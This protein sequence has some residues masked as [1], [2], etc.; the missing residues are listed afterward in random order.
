MKKALRINVKYI[1]KQQQQLVN[2][3]YQNET[4]K[5]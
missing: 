5:W 2:D 1:K 3:C 4:L